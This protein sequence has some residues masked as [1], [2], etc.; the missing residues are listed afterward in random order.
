[1]LHVGRVGKPVEDPH[2]GLL[3]AAVAL[4]VDGDFT[5]ELLDDLSPRFLIE[6]SLKSAVDF[7]E[8]RFG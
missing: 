6:P 8:H 5:D 3:G 1:M 7:L 4:G 2:S